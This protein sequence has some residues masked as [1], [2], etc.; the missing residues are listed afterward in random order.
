MASTREK[1]LVTTAIK[2]THLRKE[3]EEIFFLGEW[4]KDYK[5][6]HLLE[7]SDIVIDCHLKDR[8]KFKDNYVYLNEFNERV[9][10]SIVNLLNNYHHENKTVKYWRIIIGP[11]LLTYVS[12]VWDHW[13][14]L[15]I[16]CDKYSFDKTV[17]LNESLHK[18][19]PPLNHSDAVNLITN[20]HLWNHMLYSKI[21]KAQYDND[22]EFIYI[23]YYKTSPFQ[24]SASNN[25]KMS[26]KYNIF[27]WIDRFIGV[28]RK[29]EKTV[30]FNT[31]FSF[32][33]LIK[34]CLNLKLLPRLH[35]EFNKDIKMPKAS[36]RSEFLLDFKENNQ[37]ELFIKNDI[38]QNIP[39]SYV[40]GYNIIYDN[41]KNLSKKCE[42]IFTANSYWSNDMFKTFC[43]NKVELGKKLIIS[44]HGGA[45][46]FKYTNFSHEEKISDIYA[47]WHKVLGKNQVQVQPNK[48]TNK[49]MCKKIGANL[50][51]LGI[52]QPLYIRTYQSGIRSSLVLEDYN[53]KISFI[54]SLNND[55][56]KLV[57]IRTFDDCG[58]NTRQR[59][60]DDLSPNN[61]SSNVSLK[62]DF[63][64]ARI[65][66]CTYPQTTF[67]EAMH[68]KVP[69]ILLYKREYYEFHPKYKKLVESLEE[70]KILFSNPND[71]SDHVNKIWENPE[72][73][74]DQ[75][76][77]ISA[78]VMFFEH[79]GYV[80][81][82]WLDSWVSFFR[83]T[84]ES[85]ITA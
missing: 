11:W 29:N 72:L 40:E 74:W 34:I 56:Q 31:F 54:K 39:V 81:K 47:V 63:N 10:L 26:L 76:L 12:S 4:C 13:E 16:A 35:V 7:E 69:T 60:I 67:L 6:K 14:S 48:I 5:F 79:C 33:S 38:I 73:W 58:W 46:G 83:E 80:D 32:S 71:A 51:I 17:L 20:S 52:Q 18:R 2:E 23:N 28:V 41:V 59:Y 68:S 22:I 66:I 3:N 84:G 24:K 21:L 1:L 36:K 64:D 50:L 43:A 78:R 65:I 8:D 62:E 70:A 55:V 82:D 49:R 61:I 27:S 15:R 57:K 30:F 85:K 75:P 37:F 9:L 25:R 42:V 19:V 45:I 53:Q 44:G 77:V